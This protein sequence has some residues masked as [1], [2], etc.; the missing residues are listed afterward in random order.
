MRKSFRRFVAAC[1]AV[2]VCYGAAE[3]QK[4]Y[5]FSK[6]RKEFPDYVAAFEAKYGEFDKKPGLVFRRL[7]MNKYGRSDGRD[8]L[9]NNSLLVHLYSFRAGEFADKSSTAKHE[10]GHIVIY[11]I[12]TE[13]KPPWLT[14]EGGRRI[15]DTSQVRAA[16]TII[17]GSA[18]YMSVQNGGKKTPALI[19]HYDFVKPVLDKAG[20]R[21]G[22]KKMLLDPPTEREMRH[23]QEYYEWIFR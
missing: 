12:Y 20:V 19:R 14:M 5:V 6:L 21:N 10:L 3:F 7:T 16:N 8:V 2:A 23:P 1:A 15:T 17:E 22:V 18:D 11:N 9:I 4:A 13:T